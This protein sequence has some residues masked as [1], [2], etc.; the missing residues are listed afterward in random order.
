M[1]LLRALDS[2]V[3]SHAGRGLFIDE[4]SVWLTPA[5]MTISTYLC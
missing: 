2:K 3:I 1:T 5:Y 4:I